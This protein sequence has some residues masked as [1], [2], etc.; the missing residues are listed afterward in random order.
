MREKSYNS[1]AGFSENAEQS[2]EER[3]LKS[4]TSS[5]TSRNWDTQNTVYIPTYFPYIWMSV[6]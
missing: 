2:Q 5:E 3:P 4:L 6:S 1:E